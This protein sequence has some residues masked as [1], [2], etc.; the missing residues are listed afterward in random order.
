MKKF[1]LLVLFAEGI[2]RVAKKVAQARANP[3]TRQDV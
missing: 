3:S 1:A 2:R